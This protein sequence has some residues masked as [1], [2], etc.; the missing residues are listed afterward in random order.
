MDGQ[1]LARLY[2]RMPRGNPKRVTAVRLDPALVEDVKRYTADFTVAVE[3]ALA[4]WLKR[5]KR[6]GAKPDPLARRLAPST[7]RERAIRG[8][9]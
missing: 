8:L 6:Q 2:R 1:P 4:L 7:P 9:G 3:E 5:A